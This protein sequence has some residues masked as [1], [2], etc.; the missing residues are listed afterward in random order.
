MAT[1][2]SGSSI[3]APCALC[4]FTDTETREHHHA[5][6]SIEIGHHVQCL[7]CGA[8]L[9]L[10]DYDYATDIGHGYQWEATPP[11]RAWNL[12]ALELRAYLLERG[13]GE[14]NTVALLEA[15]VALVAAEMERDEAR[16]LPRGQE[17]T[18]G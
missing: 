10:V 14:P 16:A 17:A 13:L 9:T 12:T 3:F 6:D 18:N 15:A 7:G 4:G 5:L 11:H 2:C 8:T 1:R